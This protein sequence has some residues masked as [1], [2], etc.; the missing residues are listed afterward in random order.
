MPLFSGP[1]GITRGKR[2]VTV[3]STESVFTEGRMSSPP[4][5]LRAGLKERGQIPGSPRHTHELMHV[6]QASRH[7]SS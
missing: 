7:L 5:L 6:C 3:I 4:R 2:T 1:P